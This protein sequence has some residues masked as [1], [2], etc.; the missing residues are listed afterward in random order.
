M[1]THQVPKHNHSLLPTGENCQPQMSELHSKLVLSEVPPKLKAK[2]GCL[3]AWKTV[4]EKSNGTHTP[5]K[6]LSAAAI[7]LTS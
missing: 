5:G 3:T 7:C 1:D 2:L 6:S 4:T